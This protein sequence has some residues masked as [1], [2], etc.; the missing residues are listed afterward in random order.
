MQILYYMLFIMLRK[1]PS[2]SIFMGVFIVNVFLK[3][4]KRYSFTVSKD[5]IPSNTPSP[6][7]AHLY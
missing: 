5:E 3:E 6:K 4:I 2:I 1:L 7:S